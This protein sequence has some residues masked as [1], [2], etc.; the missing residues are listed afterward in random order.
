MKSKIF[1]FIIIALS[2][3]CSRM[4]H[5]RGYWINIKSE[6]ITEDLKVENSIDLIKIKGS[7]YKIYRPKKRNS[8]NKS[9]S[10]KDFDKL[11]FYSI[12]SLVI[13][14]NNQVK[15]YRKLND[16]LKFKGSKKISLEK[17]FFTI[18]RD[19]KIDTLKFINKCKI[20]YIDS[21]GKALCNYKRIQKDGFDIVLIDKFLKPFV[22]RESL[23]D[24]VNITIISN[25]YRN[26]ELKK[27]Q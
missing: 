13:K 16:S 27:V 1:T 24:K 18:N 19:A 11:K 25:I 12:D 4:I 20:E 26:S 22:I 2:L 6:T 3:S 14:D 23:V 17:R 5:L 10:K 15:T 7:K 8:I 9:L 21:K